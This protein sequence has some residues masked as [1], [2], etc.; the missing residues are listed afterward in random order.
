MA[1][2]DPKADILD[3]ERFLL[4]PISGVVRKLDRVY[5]DVTE[6]ALPFIWRAEVANH[7]F[8]GGDEHKN[9]IGAGKGLDSD[10]ARRGALGEAVERYC[11]LRP[12]P[13]TC[14]L[15]ARRE[16]DGPV[17]EPE[18]LVLHS[19]EQLQ[20]LPYARYTPD[21]PMEWIKGVR[22]DDQA[23]CWIPAHAA[24]LI[25]PA[26]SPILFQATSNGL[27]AGGD[28][29]SAALGALLELVER[30]AF[31]SAWYHRLPVQ[32]IAIDTHP[33][34]RLVAIVDAYRRR[35]VA[36]EVYRLPSDHEI[37]AVA[38]LAIGRNDGDP[39]V[40]VGLGAGVRLPDAICSAVTEVGQVRP[41]I[42]MKLRDPK[43]T[44]RR[45]QLVADPAEVSELEDHDLLYTDARMLPAFDMWRSTTAE[46]L[47]IDDEEAR[48]PDPVAWVTGALMKV[49]ARSYLYDMTTSD[50][51][52]L[53]L[54]VARAFIEG[55]QPIHFGDREFRKAGARFYDLP[56]RLGL[57]D[58]VRTEREL[59]PLPHPL[60]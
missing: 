34:R 60:S 45:E 22:L 24:Y 33:D 19:D 36:I 50:I 39:A 4:S 44:E 41:A 27:A 49:G 18:L 42:R 16:L 29:Q 21:L 23:E 12:P 7:R 9:V 25:P 52:P 59:N 26:T 51:A 43:V 55:F 10:S 17:L 14:P 37:P 47:V 38:A 5:K 58:R 57:D 6:P 35:G 40:V 20:T 54:H 11:A 28:A 53:G 3:V 30:D 32:P 46:P 8:L 48:P 2:P 56:R 1:S 13:P 31:L 15:R